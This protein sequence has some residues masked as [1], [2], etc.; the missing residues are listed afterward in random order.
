MKNL[1]RKNRWTSTVLNVIGMMI[2]FTVFMIIM[3]QVHYDWK[4]DRN[5]PDHEKIFRLEFVNDPSNLDSYNI[6]ICRPFIEQ[7]KGAFPEV[8][9]VGT[10]RYWKGQQNRWSR[11]ENEEQAYILETSEM[12]TN[13]LHVFPFELLEGKVS[14]F[15]PEWSAIISRSAADMM[16]PGESPLGQAIYCADYGRRAFTVTGVYKDFPENSSV[17]SG[18][19]CQVGKQS[20]YEWSEWSSFCYMK[21]HDPSAKEQVTRQIT[22][23]F[24][25]S[26]EI[27]PEGEAGKMFR[28]GIRISN[29]HDSYFAKDIDGDTM[30]K[31]N[32]TTTNSL[33]LI[34]LVIIIIAIINFINFSIATVPLVI[35]GINTRKVL[36]SG[37]WALIRSQLADTLALALAAFALSILVLH[38]ISGSSFTY[39]ISGSM[40]VA[41]NM[42]VIAL[43][44]AVAVCTALAAGIIPAL[45]STSFQPA[46][47][48][49]GSFS[50]SPKGRLL[51]TFMVGFQFV[52][53]FILIA[54]ALYISVQTSFMKHM[55]MGFTRDQIVMFPVS[56][57]IGNKSVSFEQKL[58]QD[59]DILDV[60]WAGNTLVGNSKMGWGRTFNGQR[61]QLNVLPVATDFLDFFGMTIKEGRNFMPS[62]DLNP[63]GTFIMN[64]KTMTSFPFLKLGSRL[65]GHA[66]EPAEIVGIVKDFNFKPLQYGIDPIALYVF[67]SD[68]WWPLCMVYARISP[69]DI[70]G[71]FQYIRDAIEEFDPGTNATE[72]NIRFLDESIGGF[73]Q[74]E[75]K[76]NILI[77]TAAILSLMISLIGIMGMVD[78]ETRFR[79]KEIA[80]R[81]VHGASITDILKMLNRQYTLMTLVCFIISV[82][83]SC[84][85]M[86]TWASGF[87]YQA[88]IPVWLFL[89][90][91]F[92]V[93]LVTILTV[94]LQSYKAAGS[95]PVKALQTE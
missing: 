4:Y 31:G 76:L 25:D 79:R 86:K 58:K 87:A 5:Y 14:D 18:I 85:I 32:K 46:L 22:D 66:D 94:T 88:P 48:L 44:A 52:A 71:T 90:D 41:D 37:R 19:I 81:K 83:F 7:L 13:M 20:L 39:Y 55:D 67:G 26:F 38:L 16:F 10:Y 47:V 49:K 11:Q 50:L 51:R 12:D 63:D 2:A 82:P 75:E 80:L 69:Q 57:N 60:T 43:G 95:N 89:A 29:L 24:L 53:S 15:A 56:N 74:K 40:K 36:G 61:V 54:M 70:S 59:P 65:D 23:K 42:G 73:Y 30:G 72:T 27:D 78:I 1:F 35:K 45:Y 34:G 8:E 9:E 28:N 3:I 68:P 21:L 84:A 91:L 62:D 77:L 17:S 64:E 93:L 92:S 33:F 6:N